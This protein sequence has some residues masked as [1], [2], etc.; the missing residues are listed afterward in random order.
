MK[1]ELSRISY[2]EITVEI[3][4]KCPKCKVD[5]TDSSHHYLAE[6]QWV[7]RQQYGYIA[8]EN[9]CE[10][11]NVIGSDELILDNLVVTG[12]RCHQC[13]QA[14]ATTEE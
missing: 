14:L 11:P 8:C 6:D 2:D 4:N 10:Y 9:N 3:P 7:G 1:V 12:Y 5:F 13:G